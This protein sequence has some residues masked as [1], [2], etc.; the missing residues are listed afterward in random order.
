LV[1]LARGRE[2]GLG[3]DSQDGTERE[4][5]YPEAWGKGKWRRAARF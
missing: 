1:E 3:G 4:R 2:R 5:R